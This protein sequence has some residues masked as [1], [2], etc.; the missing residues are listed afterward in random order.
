MSLLALAAFLASLGAILFWGLRAGSRSLSTCLVALGLLLWADIVL[1]AQILSLFKRLNSM[2]GL[3]LLS[4]AGAIL[5]ALALRRWPSVAVVQGP[6][7]EWSLPKTQTRLILFFLL[8]TASFVSLANLFLAIGL[9]PS[10][11]DSIVYRFPRIYWYLGQGSL[12]HFTNATEPRPLYYPFNGSLLY[13]PLVKFGLGPR[14]FTL[15]SLTAWFAVAVT[16]YAFARNLGGP[17]IAAA[18]TA[19]LICLTPNTLILAIS[20]NDE[21]IAAWPLL[22]GLFFLHR[23]YLGVQKQDALIGFLGVAMSAGTKL[24][25]M[26]YWPM[27]VLIGAVMLW[28]WRATWAELRSWLTPAGGILVVGM[29][30][31]AV[32][33]SFSF[34][35]YNM[36]SAGRATAWEFSAQILNRPFN[37]FAA[38]QTTALFTAQMILTPV[39]DLAMLTDVAQRAATYEAFNRLTAP[40]FGWVNNGPAF[41]SAFYRF[42]GVNSPSAVMYNEQT[43]FIGFSWLVA[44]L[45]GAWL[46]GGAGRAKFLWGRLLLVALPAWMISFASSTKYI[47]GFTVYLSYA[48]VVSGPALV[49]AF[50]P[51]AR[52][53][54][55]RLRWWLLSFIAMSHFV[56]ACVG[57]YTSSGR[58]LVTLRRAVT[59][60]ASPGF[61]LDPAVIAE[62]KAAKAGVVTYSIAWGQPYWPF[63]AYNPRVPQFMA[64]YPANPVVPADAPTDAVSIAMRFSRYVLMPKLQD[65]RL[66]I[67]TFPQFP[68]WGR[69]A[70]IRVADRTTSG[71]TLI[72]NIGF[73]LGP[74]WVFAAGNGVAS[75]FPDQDK[76]IVQRF[77]ELSNFGH[78][79]EAVISLSSV[80]YGLEHGD[81]F[82]F[83][84]ELAIDNVLV[85]ATE[86]DRLP[87][88]EIK[89][90]GLKQDN[91]VLTFFVRNDK[92]G[93]VYSRAMPLRSTKALSLD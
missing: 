11:P 25:I 87:K 73:A 36:A 38:L 68:A 54:L 92:T 31:I 28:R 34:I 45:A 86:W 52:P 60:P 43:V 37:I 4:Y 93:S 23:W 72:G 62:T 69:A 29:L 58:N 20:T 79:T 35:L 30:A 22:A 78:A 40:L 17:R 76:Y 83:R 15:P 19:W 5:A 47:E 39:A 21:I 14:V 18:A 13:L 65:R 64:E 9:L 16:T 85:Q 24:H 3:L 27:F 88:Q 63:M 59:W 32:V 7:F 56:L 81:E 42:T 61:A 26:F 33:F 89:A 6:G 91:G 66:H 10:N 74:E 90:P 51:I 46:I 67:Y 70:P 82:S 53:R 71:L 77:E 50:G 48:L 41:T 1:A 8:G 57:L 12:M 84:Y 44:L 55:S 2:A 75:R 49:Y 80:V